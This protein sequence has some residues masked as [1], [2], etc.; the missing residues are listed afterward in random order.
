MKTLKKKFILDNKPLLCHLGK[1]GWELKDFLSWAAKEYDKIK[2]D[3]L[4]SPI[5]LFNKE[6][7][8]ADPA[9]IFLTPFFHQ[10]LD[11]V[12]S[13]YIPPKGTEIDTIG[14]LKF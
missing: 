10:F 2:P 4:N 3:G 13:T 7:I 14:N 1:C 8:K 9:G 5:T 12:T 11:R 6:R